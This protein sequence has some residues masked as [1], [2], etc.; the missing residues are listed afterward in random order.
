MIPYD[1]H[2]LALW[3]CF[4][5]VGVV[6]RFPREFG[7]TI[8]FVAMVLFF[9]IV[10]DRLG[11]IVFGVLSTGKLTESE[12][13]VKWWMYT[14]LILLTVLAVYGG[15]TLSFGGQW[16][17]SRLVGVVIDATVGLVNGW[18]VIGTWAYF[19]DKLGYPQ[20][21]LGWYTPP[22]SDRAAML[23]AYSPLGLIPEDQALY[24]FSGAL[25]ALLALKF[26]R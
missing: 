24:V 5:F 15:E 7:A 12:N 14:L 2:L 16:P 1:H 10:G 19:T 17:P 9:D 6:R 25:I 21:A 23:V 18:L 3:L 11:R 20:Q 4:A 8:G 13:L 26:T 22:L